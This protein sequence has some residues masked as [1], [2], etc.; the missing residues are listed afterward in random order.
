MKSFISFDFNPRMVI[1]TLLGLGKQNSTV[2]SDR[3]FE[4]YQRILSQQATFSAQIMTLLLG[5]L[6]S[7][8]VAIFTISAIGSNSGSHNNPIFWLK[9]LSWLLFIIT[10]FLWIIWEREHLLKRKVVE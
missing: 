6:A 10:G 4:N 1:G 7:G 5:F 3:D 2:I 8:A 9:E